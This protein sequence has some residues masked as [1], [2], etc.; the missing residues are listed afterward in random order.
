[1]NGVGLGGRIFIEYR[2]VLGRLRVVRKS[3][4]FCQKPPDLARPDL[5]RSLLILKRSSRISAR[6]GRISMRSQHISTRSRLISSSSGRISTDRTKNTDE[7]LLLM[8]NGDFSVSI[9]SGQLKIS[10][11]ASDPPTNPLFLGSGGSDLSLAS[12]RPVLEL[13]RTGWVGGS[14]PDFV[15]TPPATDR[16][17]LLRPKELQRWGWGHLDQR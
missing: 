12:G 8:V 16:P 1:M 5:I 11:L 4:G 3:V 10:F 15:W 17:W 14:G 6:S 2:S 9:P 13:N 7:P